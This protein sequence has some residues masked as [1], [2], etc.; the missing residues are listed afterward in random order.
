MKGFPLQP[1]GKGLGV[2]S[3]GVLKQPSPPK[4]LRL[5]EHTELEHTQSNLSQQDAKGIPFIVGERGIYPFD[6]CS[7]VCAVIVFERCL[8][9]WFYGLPYGW[10]TKIQLTGWYGTRMS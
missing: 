6:V 1:V 4:V 8:G 5:F 3:K 7:G 10:W 9:R 2:C